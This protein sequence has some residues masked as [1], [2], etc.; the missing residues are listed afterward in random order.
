MLRE[1]NSFGMKLDHNISVN[2]FSIHPP[3]AA[4][5]IIVIYWTR[6]LSK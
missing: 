2:N 5:L 1:L 4:A 3:I 6:K